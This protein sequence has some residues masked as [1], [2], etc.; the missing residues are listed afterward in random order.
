M[1]EN[2]M[3]TL[4]DALWGYFLEKHLK[5]YLS[6]SV[7]YFMATVTAAPSGGVIGIQRPYDDEIFLPYAWSAENLQPG[8]TCLVLVFGD[9][10]NA[11]VLGAGDMGEPGIYVTKAGLAQTTGNATDNTMSQAAITTALNGKANT[12]TYT[13]AN[14]NW[15]HSGTTYTIT[16]LETTHKCGANPSVEVY[17]LVGSAYQQYYGMPSKGWTISVNADGDITLT[18]SAAFSGKLVIR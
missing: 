18:A 13:F 4:A 14:G 8:Q 17:K 6:D 16:L 10:T 7:C 11:I 15:T 1:G 12:Y 5:P 2:E 9:L 3:K